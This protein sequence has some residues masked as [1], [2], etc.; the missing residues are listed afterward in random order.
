MVGL[1]DNGTRI[2]NLTRIQSESADDN[3]TLDNLE[4]G[5]RYTVEIVSLIGTSTDC[6]QGGVIDSGILSL[7]FCTGN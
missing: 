3:L 5:R 6:G 7:G 1:L 2:E 4:P